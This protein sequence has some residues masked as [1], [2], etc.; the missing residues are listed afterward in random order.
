MTSIRARL[1]N[2]ALPLLGVKRFFAQREKLPERIAKLRQAKPVR[3]R[4][5]WHKRFAIS[6]FATR[7]YPV[8]TITPIGGAQPG[9]PHLLYLHGWIFYL[10][11]WVLLYILIH[12]RILFLLWQI[13]F[14]P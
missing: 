8:V 13:I 7:G 5:K 1:V 2:L 10:P 9:A 6:E 11:C 3:P 14:I 4:A 12:R